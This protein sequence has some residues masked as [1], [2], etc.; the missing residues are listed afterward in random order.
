MQEFFH[1][2]MILVSFNIKEGLLVSIKSD[3]VLEY[4][5]T[6][7]KEAKEEGRCFSFIIFFLE[8]KTKKQKTP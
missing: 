2:R 5:K 1:V 8:K 3:M 6:Y 7:V 4:R